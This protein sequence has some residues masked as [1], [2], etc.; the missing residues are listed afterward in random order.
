MI[1]PRRFWFALHPDIKRPV[2][3]VKQIH[4][5]AEAI[6]D[7]GSEAVLIQDSA[8]F[9]PAW[10]GSKVNTISRYEWQSLS[11]LSPSYDVLVLPETFVS[12]FTTYNTFLPKVVFNQNGSYSFGLSSSLFSPPSRILDLYRSPIISHVLCVSQN[13]YRLLTSD[14]GF[15]LPPSKVSLL[16]NGLEGSLFQPSKYKKKQIAYMPRKNLA[17]SEIVAALLRS[18]PWFKGWVL[19]PIQEC[20]QSQVSQIL[21]DS[22]LFL[23]FGH[24]EGFGLPVA[25][26]LSCGCGVVGYSG[27]GGRELFSLA[28]H[29]QVGNEIAVGDWLGFVDSTRQFIEAFAT[30]PTWLLSALRSCSSSVRSTYSQDKMR[31]SILSA[32]NSID[33]CL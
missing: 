29:F 10:F 12:V 11:D 13:D 18:Q 6:T 26:A 28:K 23:S 33:D 24:P 17:D 9:H 14:F 16:V 7:L 1:Q 32:L 19:K 27:L 25:E 4:R 31:M 30:R 22:L 20:S 8:E 5:L 3:G 2:G 21:Q 15:N